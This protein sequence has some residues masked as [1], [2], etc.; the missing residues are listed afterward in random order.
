MAVGAKARSSVAA[1]HPSTEEQGWSLTLTLL[2][3]G[4]GCTPSSLDEREAQARR[5][6]MR[7][8]ARPGRCSL[9]MTQI[10]QVLP[11][12]IHPGLSTEPVMQIAVT[13][14][15]GYRDRDLNECDVVDADV[16]DSR[17]DEHNRIQP[18]AAVHP[19]GP[20]V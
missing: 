14:P 11:V 8:R 19:R 3:G 7:Q 6:R 15:S 4:I 5:R 18:G 9:C 17:H 16:L 10:W 20:V 2:A 1:G 12:P 13:P